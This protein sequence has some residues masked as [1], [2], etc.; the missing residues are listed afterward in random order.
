MNWARRFFWG[1]LLLG[2]LAAAQDAKHDWTF[3]LSGDSRNCGDVV[4]PAIAAGVHADKAQFYWHLG[5]F[6]ALYDFDQDILVD[7]NA[8]PRKLT[9]TTYLDVAWLDFIA[10][11]IGPFGSTPVFLAPGNHEF[12]NGKTRQDYIVQFADWINAP[13][14]Q[15]QRL[16][17]D[18]ADH[19]VKTY[20]HWI[21]GGVDFVTLDNA[22]VD[23][24]TQREVI[25]L[26]AV[27]KRAEAD[28]N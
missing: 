6:R 26:E 11:Q 14:I 12:Y 22:T 8:A 24:F 20:Y 4:M 28:A 17:D 18:P 5:D 9:I 23:Q 27:L 13:A 2:T 25:W 7:A 15:Q 3:A 19:A 21:E 1:F 16:K 10:N